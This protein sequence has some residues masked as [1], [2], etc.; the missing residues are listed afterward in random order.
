M[1][2]SADLVWD[3]MKWTPRIPLSI[4]SVFFVSYQA[5]SLAKKEEKIGGIKHIKR[6]MLKNILTNRK[7]IY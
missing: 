6:E 4:S 2:P 7:L 1:L 3:L 5:W